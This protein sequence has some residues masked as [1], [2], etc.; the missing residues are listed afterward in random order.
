M[1]AK[2]KMKK[3]YADVIRDSGLSIYDPIE[4][5]TPKF[6]DSHFRS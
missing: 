3:G 1:T 4:M 6:M 5:G 2:D